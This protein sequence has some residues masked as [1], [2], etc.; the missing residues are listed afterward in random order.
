MTIMVINLLEGLSDTR[1]PACVS[2]LASPPSRGTPET[3]PSLG[4]QLTSL[5][6]QFLSVLQLQDND[7]RSCLTSYP[8]GAGAW[9]RVGAERVFPTVLRSPNCSKIQSMFD[10]TEIILMI[11]PWAVLQV[12]WSAMRSKPPHPHLHNNLWYKSLSC[13]QRKHQCF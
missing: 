9:A 5:I 4:L 12:S 7:R 2:I 13:S 3:Y 11:C 1:T 8:T 10:E 6:H